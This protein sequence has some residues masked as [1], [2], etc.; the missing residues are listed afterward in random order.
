MFDLDQATVKLANVNPRAEKHGE[1]TKPALDLKIEATC[2]S[3]ALIHFHPELR[4]H[5]FKKDES[6]D[7]VDQVT[8]GEGLTALRYPKMGAIKW[9]WEGSGYTATVDYGMGGDSNIA[10]ND[11]KVDHFAFEPLNGGSVGISF[12]IIA[13][14]DPDDVG[15][16]CEF[17]QRDIELT[18]TPPE[19]KTAADLFPPVG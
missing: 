7:L 8:E 1:D 15:K 9:D 14:P 13:H 3:S 17:I 10:L 4:Q 6:P 18:L 2:P 5:L 11:V 19:P 12:R 16:L